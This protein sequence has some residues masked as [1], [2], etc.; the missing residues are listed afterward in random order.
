[1]CLSIFEDDSDLNEWRV[2]NCIVSSIPC[3]SLISSFSVF[4]IERIIEPHTLRLVPSKSDYYVATL[5][6]CYHSHVICSVFHTALHNANTPTKQWSGVR[7]SFS[8]TKKVL[9]KKTIEKFKEY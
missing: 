5:R 2:R 4:A 8:I 3:I 7:T 6:F 1:M 9:D